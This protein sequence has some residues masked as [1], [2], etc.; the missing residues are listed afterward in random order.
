[1]NIIEVTIKTSKGEGND[2][3]FTETPITINAEHISMV[4]P[5]ND[6]GGA[7][8]FMAGGT[9]QYLTRENRTDINRQI[10]TNSF[11]DKVMAEMNRETQEL[12]FLTLTSV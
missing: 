6:T 9:V 1:M 5:N 3:Q 10:C 2:K 7:V 11:H 12:K 8:I 4:M